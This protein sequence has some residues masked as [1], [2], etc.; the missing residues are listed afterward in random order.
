MNKPHKEVSSKLEGALITFISF[1]YCYS[2]HSHVACYSILIL[3]HVPSHSGSL[4]T[5]PPSLSKT[6][7]FQ[8]EGK[9]F[10]LRCSSLL[11]LPMWPLPLCSPT[12]TCVVY[13]SKGPYTLTREC[14]WYLWFY[15]CQTTATVVNVAE[16][17]TGHSTEALNIRPALAKYAK[18]GHGKN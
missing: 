5:K 17:K 2:F 16:L 9:W 4:W 3:P 11:P 13:I 18:N 10:S 14:I 15:S 12:Q 1:S 6:K 8:K 7:L